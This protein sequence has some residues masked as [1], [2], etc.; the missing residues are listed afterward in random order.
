MNKFIFSSIF[1]LFIN[2]VSA[3]VLR[4]HRVDAQDT[5]ESI[6][7]RYGVLPEDI[8][9]LNPEAKAQLNPGKLLVIPN[10]IQKKASKTEEIQ[11]VVSY[12]VHRV[13]KKETLYSIAKKYNVTV[14]AIKDNN[15]QLFEAPLQFKD[16]IYIPK[17]KMRT[18]VVTS[19]ALRAYKVQPKEGKWRIAYKFGISVQELEAL[20]PNMG[21]EL[22]L[23]QTLFVPNIEAAEEQ[24]VT[25]VGFD[26][27][28][29]L[30]KEGYYRLYKKLGISQD[31]LE[32][33][34]PNLK[35]TGLKQGMVLKVP[36][37]STEGVDLYSTDLSK[38]IKYL[39]PKKIALLLPFKSNSID[40]DSIQLAKQQIQRDGY[41]RI[42]T[43]FYAGVEMALDSAKVLGISTNLD[44]FD[45]EAKPQIIRQLLVSKDFS[46][47]DL[48][49]GPMTLKNCQ[50]VAES[51]K[52]TNTAVVSP[53]VKF[54][55]RNSNLIQS[56]PGDQW[57]ADKLLTYA[58]KDSIPHQTVVISDSKS[59]N[60]IAKIRSVYPDLKILTSERDIEGKE[61]YYIEFESVQKALSPGRTLVFLETNNE[62]FASNVTSM[63]NGLNGL[64]LELQEAENEAEEEVEI[65]VER[66]LILMTTNHNKAF[67][68]SHISN[69]DLSNLNFQFPSVY[70]Y[71]EGLSDFGKNYK[72]R[73][74]NYPSR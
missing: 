53:F 18:V 73:Y 68:G 7:Q 49:L 48:V 40:F 61:Q 13:K 57:M 14:E 29:V 45:T 38:Q 19:K 34:N 2:L 25:K 27:Y 39:S 37:A 46:K 8:V 31:S 62:S 17:F 60:R 4:Q 32:Q 71:N 20:N 41:I 12:K 11:E 1:I 54:D 35:Q 58:K 9:L 15:Q 50:L 33:L 70:N 36:K 44:V 69:S 28:K 52:T 6:A 47:Y 10:P 67:K 43:E 65:E 42:A 24:T 3:Q 21:L 51:L 55:S 30:P 5:L 74:G 16:K 66:E 26:F 23:G 72:S 22:E 63:L 56:I 59:M 64:T